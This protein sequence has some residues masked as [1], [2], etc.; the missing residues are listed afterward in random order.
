MSEKDGGGEDGRRDESRH[1]REPKK[2]IMSW[3]GDLKT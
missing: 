1:D 3:L 2:E